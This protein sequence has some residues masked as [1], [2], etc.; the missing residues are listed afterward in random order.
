MQARRGGRRLKGAS[1]GVRG[2]TLA[3]GNVHQPGRVRG[4]RELETR[5]PQA[6]PWTTRGV[7][8]RGVVELLDVHSQLERDCGDLGKIIGKVGRLCEAG[9]TNKPVSYQERFDKL[10]S[11]FEAL[12]AEAKRRKAA[13]E[14]VTN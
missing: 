11:D 6:T 8:F 10:V 13:G 7:L 12:S 1:G 3:G 5:K 9:E 4:G 14:Q 2:S